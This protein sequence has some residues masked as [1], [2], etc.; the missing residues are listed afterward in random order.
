MNAEPRARRGIY[1]RVPLVR[2]SRLWPRDSA[3]ARND[4]GQR[5]GGARGELD[6]RARKVARFNGT[7]RHRRAQ[8]G[9]KSLLAVYC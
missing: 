7:L 1:R 3:T 5:A 6:A 8:T 9:L 4:K 2:S